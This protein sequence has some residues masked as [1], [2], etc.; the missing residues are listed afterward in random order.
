MPFDRLGHGVEIAVEKFDHVVARPEVGQLGEV[1]KVADQDCGADGH[2]AS[3][4][5]C[6]GKDLFACMRPDIGFQQ[7]SR[8]PVL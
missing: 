6:A 5:G 7:R 1:A 4:R 2:T 8:H 3:S